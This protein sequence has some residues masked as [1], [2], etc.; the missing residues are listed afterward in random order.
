M[1][2]I[3]AIL[4]VMLLLAVPA[5]AVQTAPYVVDDAGCHVGP[6]KV[7]NIYELIPTISGTEKEEA[8][9]TDMLNLY[10]AITAY[11]KGK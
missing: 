2:K 4:M 8:V 7:R 5:M 3:V 11:R 10:E 1:K 9:Y 6:L